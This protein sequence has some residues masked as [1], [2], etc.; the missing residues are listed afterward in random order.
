MVVNLYKPGLPHD[1]VAKAAQRLIPS[2][3]RVLVFVFRPDSRPAGAALYWSQGG[4]SLTTFIRKKHDQLSLRG[5][6]RM[7]M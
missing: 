3:L 2:L 4:S 7:K 6:S 5:I 1:A